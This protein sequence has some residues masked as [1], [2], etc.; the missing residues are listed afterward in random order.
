MSAYC[1]HTLLLHTLYTRKSRK[2]HL[3]E[4]PRNSLDFYDSNVSIEHPDGIRIPWP[5]YIIDL[6]KLDR[7]GASQDELS[8]LAIIERFCEYC[9][10]VNG[11]RK[12]KSLVE[13]TET[14]EEANEE[15]EGRKSVNV[16]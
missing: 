12:K 14:P 3:K 9:V 5:E 1:S 8:A 6:P 16:R 13:D 11:E 10:E 2:E 7:Y 15:D 4:G